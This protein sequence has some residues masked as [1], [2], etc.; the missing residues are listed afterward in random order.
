MT[1]SN[2]RRRSA[3]RFRLSALV[4]ASL[5]LGLLPAA[6]DD[7]PGK[8]PLFQV[9]LSKARD[10]FAVNQAVRGAYRRLGEPRCQ[11][12][13]SDFTEPSGRTL[14][15]T[16]DAEGLSPQ[17]H[18][19]RLL[20]YEGPSASDCR[21]PGVLAF[22]RPGSRVIYICTSWFQ[23][24]FALNPTRAEAVIIHEVLHSLGLG[25]NPPRSRDITARILERCT[26]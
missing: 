12:V 7:G 15:E 2:V 1:G 20:F 11:A 18:L 25:E 17:D 9:R 8:G 14:K 3:S 6:A 19:N 13:L 23:E 26:S 10:R 22:T 4:L 21:L 5:G 24:A 16:L